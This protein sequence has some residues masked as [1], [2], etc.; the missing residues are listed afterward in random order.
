MVD[1]SSDLIALPSISNVI[2]WML[3]QPTYEYVLCAI[4]RHF[5]HSLTTNDGISHAYMRDKKLPDKIVE[6]MYN[7]T[8]IGGYGDLKFDIDPLPKSIT[9]TR[10]VLTVLS[11]LEYRTPTCLYINLASDYFVKDD[12]IDIDVLKSVF[13]GLNAMYCTRYIDGV[14]LKK[15]YR[16]VVI[17][18]SS[19]L[20]HLK[21]ESGQAYMASTIMEVDDAGDI[22]FPALID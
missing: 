22:I 16:L 4:P 13:G 19:A 1:E 18:D 11:M 2:H 9:T 3:N 20:K 6:A 21:K 8:F 17:M 5:S 14:L 15:T 10:S 12:N 7:P